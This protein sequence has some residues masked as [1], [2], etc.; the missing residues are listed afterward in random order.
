MLAYS[1]NRC[2][3]NRIPGRF[4]FVKCKSLDRGLARLRR[5]NEIPSRVLRGRGVHSSDIVSSY[6]PPCFSCFDHMRNFVATDCSLVK[7]WLFPFLPNFRLGIISVQG[8]FFLIGFVRFWGFVLSL[9]WRWKFKIQFISQSLKR[10][11]KLI[12][13][14]FETPIVLHFVHFRIIVDFD[15]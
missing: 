8:F 15:D 4:L 10:V 5:V 12:N 7:L 2:Q 14:F 13:Y 6:W 9:R 3:P 11:Y 1:N